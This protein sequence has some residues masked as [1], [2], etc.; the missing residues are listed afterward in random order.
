MIL[1]IR[2]TT[3]LGGMA[4]RKDGSPNKVNFLAL[5]SNVSMALAFFDFLKISP[6]RSGAPSLILVVNNFKYFIG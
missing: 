6:I 3:L 1:Y 2:K 4:N 5:L